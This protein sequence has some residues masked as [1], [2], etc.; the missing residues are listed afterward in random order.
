MFK[1]RWGTH[2]YTMRPCKVKWKLPKF[3][4]R[5]EPM[6][7]PQTTRGKPPLTLP[8]N[9]DMAA[10][11]K[12]SKQPVASGVAKFP[13]PQQHDTP[14]NAQGSPSSRRSHCNGPFTA[15]HS[16]RSPGDTVLTKA[17]PASVPTWISRKR[18]YG[19]DAGVACHRGCTS[20]GQYASSCRCQ[21]RC[22]TGQASRYPIGRTSLTSSI[23]EVTSPRCMRQ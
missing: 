3:F 4:L 12:P 21:R 15:E 6:S 2:R 20:R 1:T 14:L 16:Q 5:L 7:T 10:W 11:L 9:R 18:P 17:I 13:N 22:G 23:H 19:R 8:S